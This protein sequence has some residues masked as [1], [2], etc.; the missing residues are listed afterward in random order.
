MI[1]RYYAY[2]VG[3]KQCEKLRTK[4]TVGSLWPFVLKLGNVMKGCLKYLW[5]FVYV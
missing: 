4:I 3:A 5:L 2:F 1:L